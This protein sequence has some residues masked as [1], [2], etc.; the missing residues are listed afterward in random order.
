MSEICITLASWKNHNIYNFP[1]K[2]KISN[3]YGF[4]FDCPVYLSQPIRYGKIDCKDSRKG[5]LIYGSHQH[6]SSLP[7]IST[8]KNIAL[9]Y[10]YY[11]TLTGT[12]KERLSNS[13]IV[14]DQFIDDV[15]IVQTS[16]EPSGQCK[17][18]NRECNRFS[19]VCK[20]DYP[21]CIND[22]YGL[23]CKAIAV[24][25]SIP[26]IQSETDGAYRLSCPRGSKP[27]ILSGQKALKPNLEYLR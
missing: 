3:C 23:D 21:V 2:Y 26:L 6:K 9:S 10:H 18:F 22:H 7:E 8:E 12:W 5:N 4:Q 19:G 24:C 16:F 1:N 17:C 20:S 11:H 25:P 27:N 13:S 14:G 15:V